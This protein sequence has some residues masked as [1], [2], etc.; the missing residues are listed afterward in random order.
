[1]KKLALTISAL[2]MALAGTAI[3]QDGVV[4]PAN[5]EN[6]S[7]AELDKL[8]D[9]RG[10]WQPNIGRVTGD[11]P[12]LLGEYKVRYETETAKVAA[13]PNYEI[14]EG[15]SNCE[16]EGMPTMMT[17]P[18][19]LEFLFTPGKVVINQE[20]LMQVR[21]V[22]TDGRPLPSRDEIDPTYYGYSVG[23]WE[24]DTLVVE[25]IGTR[26][27]QRLVEMGIVNSED[28]KITERLY[29]D[30][31]NKDLLHLDFTFEDPNVLAQPWHRNYTFRRDRTWEI[32]EY[33]CAENDRHVFDESGQTHAE[34]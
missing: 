24:G 9:W 29:L 1:M 21:R 28:L 34:F 16:P 11:D 8:P 31:E 12:V 13:D 25:T 26:P 30:A 20:A 2:A 19:S 10:I 15:V 23:H 6:V 27:G 14:P 5:A 18:Y 17:M 7:Y 22:F 33:V 32:L 3:A 4:H